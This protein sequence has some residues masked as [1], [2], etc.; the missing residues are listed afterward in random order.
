[1]VNPSQTATLL[2]M[3]IEIFI[4]DL[5]KRLYNNYQASLDLLLSRVQRKTFVTPVTKD[6]DLQQNCRFLLK[7][8]FFIFQSVDKSRNRK[9]NKKKG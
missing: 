5:G 8:I 7:Q 1:M 2:Y 9:K 3:S 6:I 4:Y